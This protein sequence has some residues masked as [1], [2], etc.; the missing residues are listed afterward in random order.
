MSVLRNGR[1]LRLPLLVLVLSWPLVAQAG[2]PDDQNR[3]S[4]LEALLN[5]QQQRIASLEQQ[6]ATAQA[7]D[8]ERRLGL[9]RQQ[10]RE[11]LSEQEFRESLMPTTAQAGYDKGFYIRSTDEK[12]S[13]KI[14][15][16]F[17]F[18]WTYYATRDENRYLVPGFRRH[19][20]AGFD[21][22]RLRLRFS[23]NVY[24]K[25]LTY[26]LEFD[27]S[28]AANNYNARALY[29]W[30]NYRIIDEFQFKAGQFRVAST[31]TDFGSTSTMQFPEWGLY[32]SIFGITNGTGVRLWGK[33]FGKRLDYYLDVVNSLG[34]STTATITNDEN[35]YAQGHDNNPAIIFRTVW[36]AVQ[37]QTKRP[38]DD[39]INHFDAPQ[40]FEY[41]TSPA[42]DLGFHYAYKEDIHDGSL[43]I[44]FP[45][46]TF[47]REGGYG[48]T[49]SQG[50]QIHQFAFDAAMKWAGFSL[51]GEYGLRLLDVRSSDHAPYTP[52]FLLTGEQ[53]TTAQHGGYLQ[54]G[55]LLPIPGLENKI[56]L[57]SRVG[58]IS[59]LASGQEGSWEYAGGVN[60]YIDGN[61]VKLQADMVKIY[62]LPTSSATYSYANVNDNPLIFRVQLQVAF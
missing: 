49:D 41:H 56:E 2:S 39:P 62:E 60:Y 1:W 9:M 43:R 44:P 46:K 3:I 26:Y 29:A 31:R 34:S 36:H 22:S 48:L 13:M 55:Y 61:R 28:S 30:V 35:L 57:V 16:Q 38:P 11:I 42:F 19:D 24:S 27:A 15:G 14:N 18:R 45:R 12:F 20:R 54:A 47:F 8:D 40:D 53:S 33:L 58:G 52:L 25:D 23:G 10:I 7:S 37:G 59:A 21:Y 17:Q 50:L 4:Q 32:N 51:T 6:V 5:A